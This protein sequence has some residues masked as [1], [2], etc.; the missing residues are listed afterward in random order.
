MLS[1]SVKCECYGVRS[2]A[3]SLSVGVHI[4][5]LPVK[6]FDFRTPTLFYHKVMIHFFCIF[7]L[8]FWVI[9]SR[10]VLRTSGAHS[11]AHITDTAKM[12]GRFKH[13]RSRR[14]T[15]VHLLVMSGHVAPIPP[16]DSAAVRITLLKVDRCHPPAPAPSIPSPFAS[17]SD[18]IW[19]TSVPRDDTQRR[20]TKVRGALI[21]VV[22]RL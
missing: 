2:R 10:S 19:N 7:F 18:L 13:H 8:T 9:R 14:A 17:S 11:G 5:S 1:V 12:F 15:P 16:F 22:Y 6:Y 21:S 3:S 4:S 20:H